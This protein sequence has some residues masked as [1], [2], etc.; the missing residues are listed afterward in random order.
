[1]PPPSSSLPPLQL[2]VPIVQ[3]NIAKPLYCTFTTYLQRENCGR[4]DHQRDFFH[5]RKCSVC[6][7]WW[8][9]SAPVMKHHRRIMHPRIP[10]RKLFI[11]QRNTNYNQPD[12]KLHCVVTTT[13][14]S[15]LRLITNYSFIK[16]TL[17]IKN[18]KNAKRKKAR[19]GK[20]RK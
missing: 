15:L 17:V 20:I 13:A 2:R 14:V 9:S 6:V 4:F 1:M 10:I 12:A 8:F 18:P 5:V 16:I 11:N 7:N 19:K 3:W